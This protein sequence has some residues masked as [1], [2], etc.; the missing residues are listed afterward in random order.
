[1]KREEGQELIVLGVVG[2]LERSMRGGWRVC[3]FPSSSFSPISGVVDK[4]RLRPVRSL[5]RRNK[6]VGVGGFRGGGCV[7]GVS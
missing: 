1:M 7:G 5:I 3:S 4:E 2:V 6:G